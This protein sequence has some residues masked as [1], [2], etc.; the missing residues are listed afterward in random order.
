M[1][2][3]ADWT[4]VALPT[5]EMFRM[6]FAESL[7]VMRQALWSIHQRIPEVERVWRCGGRENGDATTSLVRSKKRRFRRYTSTKSNLHSPPGQESGLSSPS[8]N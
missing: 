2:F 7:D 8:V 6:S 5:S 1:G 4:Y 3:H